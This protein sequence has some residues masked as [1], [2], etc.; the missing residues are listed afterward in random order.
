MYRVLFAIVGVAEVM[1]D[2]MGFEEAGL[3]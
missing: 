3:G 1:S 2:L